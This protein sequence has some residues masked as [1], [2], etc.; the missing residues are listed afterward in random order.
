ML[1]AVC[2]HPVRTKARLAVKRTVLRAARGVMGEGGYGRL[3]EAI[4][5]RR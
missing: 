5:S 2:E 4:I 1:Q 3:R